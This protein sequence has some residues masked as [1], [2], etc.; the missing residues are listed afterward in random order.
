MSFEYYN[1]VHIAFNVDFLKE[2]ES[3]KDNKII[4]ITSQGWTKRGFTEQIKDIIPHINIIDSIKPNP[5]FRF[6]ESIYDSIDCDLILALGGGSVLDSAKILSA[7]FKNFGELKNLVINNAQKTYSTIPKIAIPTTQGSGSE[8]TPWATIWDNENSQKYSLHLKDLYYKKAIYDISLS[9]S[10]NRDLTISTALDSLSHAV[11]SI[12]NKNANPISTNNALKAL[13]LIIKFLPDLS[14][15]L[16]SVLLREKIALGSI[17]S[18]FAFSQTQ[19][20]L[21]H[22]ISY[23]LTMKYNIPHG[24]ACSIT[25]P[26]LLKCLENKEA[27]NILTPYKKKIENLFASLGIQTE[28]SSFGLSQKDIFKIFDCLN[29]RAKN[30]LFDLEKVKYY[31]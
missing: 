16:D 25:I 10:A 1:P 13:D 4:L 5:T 15:N 27:L 19:T 7:R 29:D 20:A 28:I 21:A 23:P 22:A 17:F 26:K 14:V 31:L 30:A 2:I 6:L 18:A 24:I 3:I 8:L 12:W 11:E 9:V